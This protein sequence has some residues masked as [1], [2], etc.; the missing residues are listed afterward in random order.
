MRVFTL[1]VS[2]SKLPAHDF[3]LTIADEMPRKKK[4]DAN[5]KPR[6]PAL[7]K[8]RS[9]TQVQLADAT[10]TSQHSI[11]YYENDDGVPPSSA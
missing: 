6:L 1:S 11:S 9:L 3:G 4:E 7:R 10:K 5:F 8:A 2:I